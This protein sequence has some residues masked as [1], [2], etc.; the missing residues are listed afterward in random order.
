MESINELEKEIENFRKNMAIS[1]E[2]CSKLS[3][4]SDLIKNQTV[5]LNETSN[6]VISKF[7]KIPESIKKINEQIVSKA[8]ANI[9]NE[10]D[11]YIEYLE[12]YRNKIDELENKVELNKKNI[13][14]SI[15]DTVEK[16]KSIPKI[17][18]RDCQMS[19]AELT[20]IIEEM[21]Q[22]KINIV[23]DNA[24]SVSENFVKCSDLFTNTKSKIESSIELIQNI[25]NE[26]KSVGDSYTKEISGY[27]NNISKIIS[28]NN[29]DLAET[30][31]KFVSN[32]S[33][34][35]ERN[36][37][38]SKIAIDNLK[39]DLNAKS[40]DV[41]SKIENIGDTISSI[42][43][44]IMDNSASIAEIKMDIDNVTL[45]NNDIK[46]S[47]NSISEKNADK[48]SELDGKIENINYTVSSIENKASD[49]SAS[50]TD[51]KNG[52]ENVINLNNDI[53]ESLNSIFEKSG[54]IEKIIE[55]FDSK[56]ASEIKNIDAEILKLVNKSDDNTSEILNMLSDIKKS[57]EK[58]ISVVGEKVDKKANNLEGVLNQNRKQILNQT[59][60][61]ESKITKKI[62]EMNKNLTGKINK[63]DIESIK[64][65]NE[66]LEHLISV[67]TTIMFVISGLAVLLAILG[68]IF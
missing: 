59:L 17:I 1:G 20:V 52:I 66:N 12:K 29:L 32:I 3:N 41:D 14:K 8:I 21:I 39:E 63:I 65:Q 24:K 2:I 30:L 44:K 35:F 61:I 25:H 48:I 34:S 26:F 51:I 68:F 31:N 57:N 50:M 22:E 60:G 36:N 5:S 45:F 27:T 16:M 6:D 53:R 9:A 46:E 47:L 49:N 10:N 23:L 4:I 13:D 38:E 42:Y 11:K 19:N 15:D 28:Q 33:S 18:S 40:N 43:E 37:E 55:K 7:S 58:E 56:V 54:Q 67:R 64:K 62:E